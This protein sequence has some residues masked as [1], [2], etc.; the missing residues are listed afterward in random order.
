[1]SNSWSGN[2]Y[3][4]LSL[5]MPLTGENIRYKVRQLQAQM[6]GIDHSRLETENK[7][8]KDYFQASEDIRKYKEQIDLI[9]N[10]VT[11]MDENVVVF[12]DRS[13]KSN[14]MQMTLIY[15]NRVC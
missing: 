6:Q 15:R 14:T 13:K 1:M 9:Q 8:M 11:L 5:K 12:Q 3:M 7:L 10:N 2:S 4:G